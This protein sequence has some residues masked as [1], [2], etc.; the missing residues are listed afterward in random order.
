MGTGHAS[1]K[2]QNE[3]FREYKMK[4][5]AMEW[6]DRRSGRLI[7]IAKTIWSHPELAME[8]YRSSAILA[9]ELER[10]GFDVERGVAGMPTAFVA[11]WG[12]GSPTI[13]FICE[14][15]ALPGLSNTEKTF[16]RLT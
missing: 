8:E 11:T 1:I 9:D 15:D 7:E 5:R 6:I 14:Y 4:A 10:Q 3:E 2:G 12:S 16:V 13:G